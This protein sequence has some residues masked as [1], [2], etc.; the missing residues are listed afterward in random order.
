[1][2]ALSGV[3]S[4]LTVVFTSPRVMSSVSRVV[5]VLAVVPTLPR[6]VLVP[7]VVSVL[8]VMSVFMEVFT[9]FGVRMTSVSGVG[10]SRVEYRAYLG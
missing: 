5:S 7:G 2:S 3:V 9:S 10:P 4:V 8:S 1:M 6:M